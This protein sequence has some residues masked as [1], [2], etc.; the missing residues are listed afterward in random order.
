ML[1]EVLGFLLLCAL[2]LCFLSEMSPNLGFGIIAGIILLLSG[3]WLISDTAGLQIQDGVTQNIT[4][5]IVNTT[6]I[7]PMGLPD[8]YEPLQKGDFL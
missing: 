6:N 4:V 1:L 5:N 2:A 7:S 3:L 8:G